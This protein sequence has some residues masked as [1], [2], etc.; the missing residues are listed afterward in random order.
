MAT[1]LTPLSETIEIAGKQFIIR[2]MAAAD[3]ETYFQELTEL[4]TDDL[5]KPDEPFDEAVIKRAKKF[6]DFISK[7]LGGIDDEFIRQNITRS[8][9]WKIIEIQ[10]KLNG[11]DEIIKKVLLRLTNEEAKPGTMPGTK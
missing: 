10:N 2:E 1:L 11:L 4:T 8:I 3:A 9:A 6:N 7:L 5:E